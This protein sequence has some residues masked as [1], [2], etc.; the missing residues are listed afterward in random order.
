MVTITLEAEARLRAKNQITV[1]ERVVAAL[2][3]QQDDTLVFEA[4]AAE[5]GVIRVRL[6]PRS[7]AG[8][9]TGVYGTSAEVVAF[10]REERAAWE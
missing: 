2:D 5:P 10:L 1:P 9:L 4:D 8:S 6:L 7:F 3:A